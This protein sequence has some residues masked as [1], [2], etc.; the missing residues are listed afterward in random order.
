MFLNFR[1]KKRFYHCK[2]GFSTFKTGFTAVKPV[3]RFFGLLNKFHAIRECYFGVDFP[4][5]EATREINTKITPRAS[6]VFVLLM[7]LQ[8]IAD[9]V[10]M[11]FRDLT[12]VTPAREE[13]HLTR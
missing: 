3:L 9:D 8:Y 13:R 7:T 4:R 10:T 6:P 1:S 5:C 2:T 11:Q 12:I